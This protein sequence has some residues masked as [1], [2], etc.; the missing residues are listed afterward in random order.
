MPKKVVITG[1][2]IKILEKIYFDFDSAVIQR[3]SFDILFQVAEVLRQNPQ[4]LSVEVQGHTD[5]CGADAYNLKLSNRRAAAVRQFLVQRGGIAAG[6]LDAKGYG[7][8]QPID[9]GQNVQAWDKNRRVEFIIREEAPGKPF[10]SPI[11]P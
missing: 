5:S 8:T 4:I 10:D 6:R 7:E 3:R 11:V 1:G 2:K 9:P